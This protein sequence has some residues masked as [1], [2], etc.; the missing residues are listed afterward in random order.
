MI[1]NYPS[2]LTDY[3]LH[4]REGYIVPMQDTTTKNFN[5]SVDLQSWPID[6]HVSGSQSEE[7]D[8]TWFSQGRYINDDG[9]TLNT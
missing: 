7:S 3:Q 4:L 2:G 9:V 8:G 5:T 6:L 1:K